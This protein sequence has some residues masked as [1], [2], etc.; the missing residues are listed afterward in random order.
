MIR[1]TFRVLF[2]VLIGSLV[3]VCGPAQGFE[4]VKVNAAT[5]TLQL[6]IGKKEGV[7]MGTLFNVYRKEE[8][9]S[10]FGNFTFTTRVFVGRIFAVK[11]GLKGTSARIR[12]VPSTGHKV[13]NKAILSGDEIE[14]VFVIPADDLFSPGEAMLRPEGLK[15]LNRAVGFIKRFKSILFKV[16]IEVHTDKSG[17]KKA[18]MALSKEQAQ[19]IR[20]YL[21]DTGNIKKHAFLPVGYGYEKPI[22][23]NDAPEGRRTNRRVEIVIEAE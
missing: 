20:D 12:E 4:V 6:N 19:G 17:P 1:F 13:K 8:I 23:S 2:P 18:D 11:V 9:G 10:D 22:A 15:K 14:P 7:L 3:L 5:R 16:R 21:V